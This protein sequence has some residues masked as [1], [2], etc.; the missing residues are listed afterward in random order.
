ML[1]REQAFKKDML[2][3]AEQKTTEDLA[4]AEEVEPSIPDTEQTATSGNTKDKHE[5]ARNVQQESEIKQGERVQDIPSA[6][7]SDQVY[8]FIQADR[9]NEQISELNKDNNELKV[10]AH[11]RKISVT[12]IVI[13]LIMSLL[14]NGI[15][16]HRYITDKLHGV[17]YAEMNINGIKYEV[18]VANVEVADGQ[19]KIMIYG[20]T[21][22]NENGKLKNVAVPLGEFVIGN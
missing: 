15:M 11:K 9:L 22:T 14:M 1:R 2:K 18:P 10:Q 17:D 12:V 7:T 8:K 16:L 4:N 19:K 6:F 13:L 20:F 21:V 3:K 5:T